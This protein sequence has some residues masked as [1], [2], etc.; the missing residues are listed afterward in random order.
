[1]LYLSENRITSLDSDSF[2][3]LVELEHLSLSS[4]NLSGISVD[5]FVN[6]T[7]LRKK[8]SHVE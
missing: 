5:L 7:N 1:M 2:V 3:D 8:F 4:D 6:Q